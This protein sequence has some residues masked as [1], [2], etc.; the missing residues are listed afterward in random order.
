[1]SE[2]SS[3]LM[4]RLLRCFSCLFACFHTQSPGAGIIGSQGEFPALGNNEGRVQLPQYI[5]RKIGTD[6]CWNNQSSVHR[7]GSSREL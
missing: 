4:D 6:K 1:M 5:Y 7:K 2:A 3:G